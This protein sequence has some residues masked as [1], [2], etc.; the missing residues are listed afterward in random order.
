[1]LSKYDEIRARRARGE[2]GFSLIE[3]LVVVVIMGIL[4]AI[5]VPVYI[6][7]QNGAKKRSVEADVRNAVPQVEQ[8]I[9]DH[10]GTWNAACASAVQTASPGN[11]VSVQSTAGGYS[12]TGSRVSSDPAYTTSIVNV[13]SSPASGG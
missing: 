7:Y 1:M 12:I 9:S 3:L 6:N 2:A 5:A 8:C 4:I 10:N 11:T 13:P